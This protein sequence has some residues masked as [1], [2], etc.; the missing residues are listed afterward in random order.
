MCNTKKFNLINL[1]YYKPLY[2]K[3]MLYIQVKLQLG[4]V[5][6][7]QSKSDHLIILWRA[8]HKLAFLTTMYLNNLLSSIFTDLARN[9]IY[10]FKTSF[11]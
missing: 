4:H 3:I 2:L 9:V 5:A 11:D 6:V 1:K 8:L 10:L 7:G